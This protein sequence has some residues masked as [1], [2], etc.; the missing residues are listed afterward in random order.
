MSDHLQARIVGQLPPIRTHLLAGVLA[1]TRAACSIPGMTRIALIGSLATEKANPKDA[2]M[3]V[4]IADADR[5]SK[6]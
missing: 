1:F 4:T 5:R 6:A 2:D 3:L